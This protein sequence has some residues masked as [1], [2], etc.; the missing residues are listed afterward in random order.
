M[1]YNLIIVGEIVKQLPEELRNRH[2][3][4]AWS[5]IARFRDRVIHYYHKTSDMRVWE[6]ITEDLL[7]LKAK[8][9]VMLAELE[10]PAPDVT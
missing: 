10:P 6:A 2:S 1:L 9:L 3:D 4:Y 8:V 7:P 5:E